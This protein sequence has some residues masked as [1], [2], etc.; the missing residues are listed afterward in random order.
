VRLAAFFALVAPSILAQTPVIHTE[1]RL[2]LVDAVVTDKK[3]RP[4]GDLAA[5]DFRL[6]EDGREQPVRSATFGAAGAGSSYVVLLFADAF[7]DLGAGGRA[8]EAAAKFVDANAAPGHWVAIADV[9]RDLRI[10]QNF[11]LDTERLKRVLRESRPPPATRANL[12]G[13]GLGMGGRGAIGTRSGG[14]GQGADDLNPL[15]STLR[16]L[17]TNLASVPGR[18]VVVLFTSTVA[19]TTDS[20][21]LEPAIAAAN[22]WN[23]SFYPVAAGTTDLAAPY[24]ELAKGTG[25]FVSANNRELDGGLERLRQEAGGYYTLSY[26]PSEAPTGSC[27]A[28]R[29]KVDRPGVDLRARIAYC[30]VKA[31]DLLAGT[32]AEKEMERH[33]AGGEP[34]NFAVSFE[35]PFF[36]TEPNLA[37]LHMA[38]EIP[39]KSLEF[40]R[41]KGKLHAELQILAI[42]V[43][44]DGVEGARFSDVLKLDFSKR[45]EA[46]AFLKQPLHYEGQFEVASGKYTLKVALATGGEKYG[47]LERALV[48]DPYDGKQLMLSGL[49]LSKRI[50]PAADPGQTEGS[51]FLEGVAPLIYG[52][53]RLVPSG[54]P[55]FR[56]GDVAGIYGE[57][58]EPLSPTGSAPSVELR[59]RVVDLA[60]GKMSPVGAS[61][62]EA[63]RPGEFAVIPFALKLFSLPPG[64]YRAEV[65]AV[66]CAVIRTL[67]FEVR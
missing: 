42:A 22:R 44:P 67:D 12:P 18:K 61:R 27:H 21:V 56:Q 13:A 49:A 2:V 23:V 53:L 9:D 16:N 11:T 43:Q 55:W 28:L 33:V 32:A 65:A 54:D 60:T 66:G 34:G 52:N 46:D 45:E 47:G 6:W 35:A 25:G 5:K 15:G 30:N 64:R 37:M 38:M 19:G 57:V 48:I 31:V 3:G 20:T 7:L 41:V 36:Y 29:V 4:V 40:T 62:A 51:Q 26:V 59:L 24:Y 17:A 1:S 58:Y 8:R 63:F 50:S 39:T 14:P 10:T